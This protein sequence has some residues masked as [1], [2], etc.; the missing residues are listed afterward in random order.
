MT[1]TEYQQYLASE[2][3]Q[4]RRQQFLDY[5]EEC[6]QCHLPR[7]LAQIAYD[8]D[9]HV[10]HKS[11]EN[12][13]SEDDAQLEAL[14][15]RCHEIVT[16]GRSDLRE[17]KTTICSVCGLEHYNR[18]SD[19]C[20]VCESV[21]ESLI[22]LNARVGETQIPL[23]LYMLEEILEHSRVEHYAFIKRYIDASAETH[24]KE[25]LPT[26]YCLIDAEGDMRRVATLHRDK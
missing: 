22:N 20:V 4:K 8:N 16:F 10:H 11:Y 9:L 7:W 13:G 25:R 3:W 21:I 2:Y 26:H 18:Y 1:K 24:S 23:W 14:C 17:I 12:L 15:K 19:Y 5:N 6:Y